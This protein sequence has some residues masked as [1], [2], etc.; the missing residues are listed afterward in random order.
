MKT[1][2]VISLTLLLVS[3]A[4]AQSGPF[5]IESIREIAKFKNFN[6]NP[7]IEIEFSGPHNVGGLFNCLH[8]GKLKGIPETHVSVDGT[9]GL[10]FY[11]LIEDWNTVK[12]G[13]PVWITWGCMDDGNYEKIKP[14]TYLY[15]TLLTKQYDPHKPVVIVPLGR[16][17]S[18]R[19]GSFRKDSQIIDQLRLVVR[20]RAAWV[21]LWYRMHG[22]DPRRPSI[23]VP[24]MPEID[25]SREMLIVASMGQRPT[26]GYE[27]I[28]DR[29]YTYE[30][31]RRLEVVVR[32]ITRQCDQ[33]QGSTSPI[34]I[35]RLPQTD[36]SVVFRE[37]VLVSDCRTTYIR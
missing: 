20:D 4:Y 34:D 17:T 32:T 3:S 26:A 21:D 33:F 18:Q 24:S 6:N 29:A 23:T 31:H 2:T 8:I 10:F 28:I 16:Q 9:F 15:K 14:I 11:M 12:D 30:R 27:I 1:V 22:E 35:V 25:F 37:S 19:R 5:E 7:A 36:R 13:S